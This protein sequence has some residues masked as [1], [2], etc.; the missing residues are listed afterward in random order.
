MLVSCEEARSAASLGARTTRLLADPARP[1]N[2]HVRVK[3]HNQTIFL[4]VDPNDAFVTLKAR[5]ASL[6]EVEAHACKLFGPDRVREL[7]DVATIADQEIGD[8]DCLYVVL[9]KPGESR[10]DSGRCCSCCCRGHRWLLSHLL[11]TWRRRYRPGHRSV[12][13]P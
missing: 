2:R 13:A 10:T 7:P 9:Q 12:T 8:D 4:P 6:L 11:N 3:R 1:L 5:L